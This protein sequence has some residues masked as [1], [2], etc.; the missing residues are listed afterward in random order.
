VALFLVLALLV[1]YLAYRQQAIRGRSLYR[2][3]VSADGPTISDSRFTAVEVSP[4]EGAG[5]LAC[6]SLD[7]YIDGETVLAGDSEKAQYALGAAM[8]GL[9]SAAAALILEDRERSQFVYA[10]FILL[11]TGDRPKLPLESLADC[12]GLSFRHRR[13]HRRRALHRYLGRHGDGTGAGAATCGASPCRWS[14]SVRSGFEVL[15]L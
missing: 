6:G 7:V 12:P 3:G 5:R 1:S 11:A 2:V 8:V 9:I 15:C 4:A 13:L 10:L 14:M